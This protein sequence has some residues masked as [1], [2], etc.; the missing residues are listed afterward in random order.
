MASAADPDELIG[1]ERGLPSESGT[2]AGPGR[3]TTSDLSTPLTE[4][5]GLCDDER[6]PIVDELRERW[7][8]TRIRILLVGEAKRGKSTVGNALLG[9]AV[10]PTGALPL[11]A[12]PTTVRS[13]DPERI[14]I[15]LLDG[16]IVTRTLDELPRYVTEAGNPGNRA[17]V[18]EVLVHVSSGALHR[19]V[20]LVDTPG[21][22]S[23]Y[24]HNTR[25]AQ[26]ARRSVDV[27]VLVL[28]ADPPIT[29]EERELV[30]RLHDEAARIFVVLNKIDQL[31]APDR[32]PTESF[33]RRV[34]AAT[35]GDRAVSVF[36]VSARQ[37]VRAL[38]EGD[39]LG[40]RASGMERFRSTLLA[41]LD[42][43]W[44]DDL[45]AGVAGAALRVAAELVDEAAVAVRTHELIA[46]RQ[47]ERVAAFGTGLD[48]LTR[49]GDD[50]A[51]AAVAALA[52]CQ[53]DLDA[54]AA[55]VLAPMTRSVLHDLDGRLEP[56][57]SAAEA[58]TV[59]WP[60]IGELVV[61]AVG[62]WRQGWAQRISSAIESAQQ[63][64]GQLLDD[65]V[66]QV[67]T[68]TMDLLGVELIAPT[69]VAAIPGAGSFHFD[70]A[71]GI[72]W[73][74]PVTSAV[75][76]HVPGR[77]G[78]DRMRRFLHQEATRSVDKHIGRARAD[79]QTALTRVR[80]ELRT[81]AIRACTIRRDQLDEAVRT[82]RASAL[83]PAAAAALGDRLRRLST[84]AD[85]FGL[86][87]SDALV[88][89][90]ALEVEGV[91]PH[92]PE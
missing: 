54:D 21:V 60:V 7:S 27:A 51:A 79:F 85:Q 64:V 5:V 6:A 84:L 77:S 73:N 29:A 19:R 15:R 30:A 76:R 11:T 53:R 39:R 28:S 43:S 31:E 38:A 66:A 17:G 9:R 86:I 92:T 12:V 26:A 75:R 67:R 59:G 56:A 25:A 68:S 82:A 61:D 36:P 24:V 89:S 55:A 80:G 69:P 10:L 62:D 1:G 18:R 52:R 81:A 46:D 83:D 87:R 41:Q 42:R 90:D 14:E 78:R 70:V 22:G 4:L 88:R 57:G 65:A 91:R 74:E 49:A 23:V 47:D 16:S 72:G 8:A 33:T 45:A 50:A 32:G 34:V 63:R 44:Q 13:G 2:R 71:P 40:W 48:R 3:S 37:G 58:E 20:D 35:V